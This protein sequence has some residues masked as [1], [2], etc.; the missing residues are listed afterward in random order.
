MNKLRT[1]HQ[2]ILA[3][4]NATLEEALNRYEAP[5]RL[6]LSPACQVW[7]TKEG[8]DCVA[9]WWIGTYIKQLNYFMKEEVMKCKEKNDRNAPE[10]GYEMIDRRPLKEMEAAFTEA[11]TEA[12]F[13]QKPY[14]IALYLRLIDRKK[15]GK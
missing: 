3:T 11:E 9:T 14:P 4:K 13:D 7:F 12:Q 10:E 6:A 1:L 2:Q 8:D 5:F 15:G